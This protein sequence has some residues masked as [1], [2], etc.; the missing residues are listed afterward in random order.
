MNSN[1]KK[2][3]SM[4][5]MEQYRAVLDDLFKQRNLHQLKITEIDSAIGALR[6]LMP[7]DATAQPIP[8]PPQP[9]VQV[10][11]GRFSGLGVRWA[12]LKLL[13]EEAIGPMKTGEIATALL[14]GG[15]SS[16]GKNFPGNV[17]AVLSDMNRV[18]GEVTSG[19]DGYSLSRT[20]REVWAHIKASMERNAATASEQRPLQ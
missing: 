20:G 17:S 2:E 8:A 7:N 13:A 1:G 19:E 6:R 10:V 15:I 12:I 11:P 14:A 3:E 4:A 9:V 18:R 5:N 16:N